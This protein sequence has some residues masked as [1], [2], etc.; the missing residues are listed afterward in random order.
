MSL[1]SHIARIQPCYHEKSSTNFSM[2]PV[3][4]TVGVVAGVST[5]LGA[6]GKSISTLNTFRVHLS[7]AELN[8]ELLIGQLQ[9]VQA[10]LRQVQA[11]LTT[12]SQPLSLDDQT[13]IIDLDSS[14][15]HCK[16]LVQYIDNQI[17]KFAWTP[18]SRITATKLVTLLA[19][20]KA[21]K[22]CLT[23]LDHQVSAL[24]LCLTAFRW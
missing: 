18:G 5:I 14:L 23:R 4:A 24:N 1:V 10:A 22:S 20:D 11:F 19:E 2:D 7:D 9:T 6:L 3:T 13:M 8:I 16:L 17:S 15:N 21:T 12:L